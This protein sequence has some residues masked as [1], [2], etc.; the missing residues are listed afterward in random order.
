[1]RIL[2]IGQ[3]YQ[4]E[5]WTFWK[6]QTILKISNSE[7]NEMMGYRLEKCAGWGQPLVFHFTYGMM[8]PKSFLIQM[9][10]EILGHGH[11]LWTASNWPR[12]SK[13][14]VFIYSLFG[15]FMMTYF[16]NVSNDHYVI[17]ILISCLSLID[18]FL[19]VSC[20]SSY[21]ETSWY[22]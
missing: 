13:Y 21:G 15:C 6:S 7:N 2:L 10:R 14:L 16:Y 18:P 4:I 11:G 8:N 1:M 9:F 5:G 3:K 19:W 17:T 12:S 20:S 22:C